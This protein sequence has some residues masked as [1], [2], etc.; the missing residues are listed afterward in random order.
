[1]A[2]PEI[3]QV[4]P[5]APDPAALEYVARR[6]SEGAL[7]G[8]PT[9]TVYGV[10]VDAWNEEALERLRAIKARPPDKPFA[11]L[12][13]SAD[14]LY[15]WASAVPPLAHRLIRLFWPGPLTLV[16]PARDG[17]YVGLRVPGLSIARDIVALSG[18]PVATSSANVSGG[19]EPVDAASVEKALGDQLDLL[20]DA[21]PSRFQVSSTV[22]VVEPDGYRVAREGAIPEAE[23]KEAA[24]LQILF[25]C[26]GNTCRSPM[27]Q[28]LM[29]G[30]IAG[31]LG[32]PVEDLPAYG[33]RVESAG[34]GAF[35]G[36]PASPHAVEAL[37][38]K[39]IRLSNH[40]SRPVNP[41]RVEEADRVY[42]MT[43]RH[44][45]VLLDV[46]HAD[47]SRVQRIDPDGRDVADPIGGDLDT[48]RRTRDFLA[49][50]VGARLEEVM[51]LRRDS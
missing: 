46:G 1:M 26:T 30:A 10:G 12:L 25:V 3:V 40:R 18:K 43:R 11:L 14:G 7:V 37:A 17:G 27:A 45:D 50:A 4:D 35:G 51:A 13:A 47:P 24:Y 21:G 48:Y 8:L 15:R 5:G 28:G 49:R 23:V 33:V 29:A 42:V 22:V 2:K 39:G 36:A 19:A 34:T 38:E 9:D 41:D 31:R 20:V 44:R 6:L 32:V 16:L